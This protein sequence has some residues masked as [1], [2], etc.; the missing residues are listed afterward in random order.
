MGNV[1]EAAKVR[2]MRAPH[3]PD[4]AMEEA[5]DIDGLRAVANGDRKAFERLYLRYHA[6]LSRFLARHA[7]QRH[8]VDEV[9][10]ETMWVVWRTAGDFR[11]ESK[12]GTWIIGIAY[13]CFLKML[14]DTPA[15]LSP[16]GA[17][18]AVDADDS[19]GPDETEARETRDWVRRGLALLPVE[20]RLTMELV[21]YLGQSYEEVARIMECAVGTVKARMF[22]ARV[23]L[24]SSL[25]GLGGE[26]ARLP[27]D[28][29]GE[30]R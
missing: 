28:P 3:G 26:L 6:R 29:A 25:P 27:L 10:N 18:G 8:Q 21:Y 22:H 7:L 20:Q 14:R 9:I 1:S 24:R 13:R 4:H 5:R 12:V 19:P 30:P 17:A 11:G 23:R 2:Q 16:A 15:A